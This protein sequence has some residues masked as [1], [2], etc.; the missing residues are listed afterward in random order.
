[1]PE[2]W[3]EKSIDALLGLV[4]IGSIMQAI[5]LYNQ[6]KQRRYSN[7][8]SASRF[9]NSNLAELALQRFDRLRVIRC[10]GG[11]TNLA[12]SIP[13]RDLQESGPLTLKNISLPFNWP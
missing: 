9:P 8:F 7:A 2:F 1:M 10:A 6:L 4:Q 12:P 3:F 13:V 11:L 5:I